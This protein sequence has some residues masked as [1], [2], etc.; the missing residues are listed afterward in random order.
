[1]KF[2]IRIPSYA[3]PDLTY[4]GARRL[5]EYCRKVE[6]L[7]FDAIWVI[8]HFIPTPILYVVSWMEP[9]TV[10]SFAAAVTERIRL[11]TGILV[12]PFRNPVLL[13]K[14]V[15]TLD[16]LSGG[17]FILGVGGGWDPKEFQVMG[18][19]L[20]ERGERTDEALEIVRR[21]LTEENVSFEGRYYKFQDLT[22]YPRPR[23]MPPVWVA[24]GS[25]THA[26]G[27][28]DKPYMAKSVLRRI[29][30]ADAWIGRSSGSDPEDIRRDLGEVK[31]YLRSVG[32]DPA[33][34]IYA[35]TQFLHLVDTSDGEE[36][37]SL[38]R[39]IFERV[40]G[41]HRSIDDLRASYLM[42]TTEE[43]VARIEGLRR[44]GIQYLILNPL[45]DDIEQLERI[46]SQIADRFKDCPV[47]L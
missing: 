9:L 25:L 5:K 15:A 23:K 12:L 35:H 19:S 8:D 2:G 38:Q 7:S 34:L 36:A 18:V 10:L 32:R 42:G 33:T 14:E 17:R 45:T 21:L 16:H 1:M 24:G 26:A 6:E 29:A 37:L 28:P 30:Q 44:V 11:G 43:I 27:A 39:P 41:T 40:M 47:P 31:E 13:A 22:I 3:W 4:E 20:K 46:A